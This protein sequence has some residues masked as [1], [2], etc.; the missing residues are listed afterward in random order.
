MLDGTSKNKS[1]ERFVKYQNDNDWQKLIGLQLDQRT[2]NGTD[3]E[4]VSLRQH[5]RAK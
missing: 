5:K 3:A 1:S 2:Y 4:I